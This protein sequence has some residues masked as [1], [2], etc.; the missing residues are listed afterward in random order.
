MP[1]ALTPV[2]PDGIVLHIGVHKS[3]TTSLQTRLAAVRPQLAARGITYAGP[4]HASHLPAMALVGTVFG[5]GVRDPQRD[6]QLW[7]EFA[8]SIR[9]TRGRVMIS[10][11]FFCQADDVQARRAVDELGADRVHLVLGLRHLGA[12]LPSSWQQYLKTGR[13]IGYETWLRAVL[14]DPPDNGPTPSF[15]RRNDVPA[16]LRRWSALVPADR[17]TV[18][19][20]DGTP[21][22]LSGVTAQLLGVPESLLAAQLGDHRGNRSMTVAEAELVR[23]VNKVAR[24]RIS[25]RRYADMMRN[26]GVVRMVESRIP[27]AD[28]PRL[29]L[30]AWALPRVEELAA[31]HLAALRASG[32]RVVGDADA[33]VAP[34][35]ATEHV[36]PE[37][38]PLD[39]AVE[40]LVG[41]LLAADGLLEDPS[42]G[43]VPTRDLLKTSADRMR[44]RITQRLR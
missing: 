34:L 24:Q 38:V 29:G 41:T 22:R 26:G 40:I 9:E 14:A 11:E 27:H 43:V 16:L 35:T 19:I 23:A 2:G 18:V 39:A 13:R 8:E 17:M 28:E 25:S 3:G 10:S 33:L 21:D 6:E 4:D 5:W 42:L 30:P 32:V 7:N 37:D 31:S 1:E 15:W 36:L 12:L 20:A 44:R